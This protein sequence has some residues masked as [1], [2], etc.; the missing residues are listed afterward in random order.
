MGSLLL[1]RFFEATERAL[2]VYRNSFRQLE[3]CKGSAS[4]MAVI[5]ESSQ[6]P[7]GDVQ[8][9]IQLEF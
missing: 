3:T 5:F 1:Q 2:L 9:A 8:E 4:Q 7:Q 6:I